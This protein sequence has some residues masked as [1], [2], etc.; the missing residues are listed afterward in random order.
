MNPT[1]MLGLSLV[2]MSAAVL[3]G[4]SSMM[5]I[6][7]TMI[8]G[9]RSGVLSVAGVVLGDLVWLSLALSGLGLIYPFLESHWFTVRLLAAIFLLFLVLQLCINNQQ[10]PDRSETVPI[11]RHYSGWLSGFI[12]TMTDL[13]A[14]MF[15]LA[16]LPAFV[17]LASLSTSDMVA[18]MIITV[19]SVGLGKL[20]YVLLTLRLRSMLTGRWVRSLRYCSAML[21]FLVAASLLFQS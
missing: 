10:S 21:L 16:I 13:K 1:E 18:V 9:V 7:N 6:S 12:V 8:S 4:L 19:V 3:P 15:Y 14:V 20:A 5:V 11:K 2:L 17:D